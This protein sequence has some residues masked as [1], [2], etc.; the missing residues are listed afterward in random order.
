VDA[1]KTH[2]KGLM[3]QL[4][5]REGETQ[6]R[7][8]FPEFQN[9]GEWV[10]MPF[11]ELCDIKHGYPFESEFFSNEDD[12]VLLTPGNFYEEGGYRD[13][14]EKQKYFS[15]EIPR[16]YVLTE[17]DMLLAMTEQAAGLLGSPIIVPQSDRFL[18]N[19]RLGL[20]TK[21]PGVAW[22]NEFFFHVFNTQLV[23]K[24]IHDTASGTKVRHT[25]PTK[26]GEV[27]VSV[28]TTLVE[29]EHIASCLCSLDALITAETQKH[30]VLKTHK[31]GLMQ[32]LFPSPEEVEP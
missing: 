26:I 32:Q 16:D 25:S 18:H 9:A 31:K 17:G 21:R 22:T 23:R 10:E 4:F 24:A 28:P 1:L 7:L 19:Q 3:Q 30:E 29:Q 14:G 6:P 15:G 27:V 12:Y 13:R 8:R 5:P 20:V 11:S 2:K